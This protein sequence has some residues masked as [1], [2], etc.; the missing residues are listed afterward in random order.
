[1][2]LIQWANKCFSGSDF[3]AEINFH[4]TIHVAVIVFS[5]FLYCFLYTSYLCHKC[6]RTGSQSGCLG[7]DTFSVITKALPNCV[8]LLSFNFYGLNIDY[9]QIFFLVY[10]SRLTVIKIFPIIAVLTE[11][12]LSYCSVSIKAFF[13]CSVA[14]ETMCCR[15]DLNAFVNASFNFF[16]SNFYCSIRGLA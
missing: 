12:N 5:Y 7:T 8:I 3:S 4:L 16:D 9:E 15:A 14:N 2:G 13:F 6:S 11:K 10:T 1:M